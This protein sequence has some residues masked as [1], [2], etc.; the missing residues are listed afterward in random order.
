[1]QWE[2]LEQLGDLKCAAGTFDEANVVSAGESTRHFCS[3]SQD[4]A[5][6]K[7]MIIDHMLL[8]ALT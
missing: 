3:L 1:L 2:Y 7:M 4:P 8:S 5:H 6:P